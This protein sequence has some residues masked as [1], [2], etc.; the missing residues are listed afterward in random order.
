MHEHLVSKFF[1][2]FYINSF[3]ELYQWSLLFFLSLIY[4]KNKNQTLVIFLVLGIVT[5]LVGGSRVNMMSYF[6]F[7]FYGLQYKQGLNIGVIITSLYFFFKSIPFVYSIYTYGD[8]FYKTS[9]F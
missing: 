9:I 3:L 7:L 8:G 1:A 4:S 6:V 5:L 2:Y